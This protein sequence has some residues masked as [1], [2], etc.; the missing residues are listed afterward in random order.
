[1]IRQLGEITMRYRTLLLV[2]GFL[3]TFL[4]AACSKATSRGDSAQAQILFVCEHGNVKSLMAA[5]YFNE[6]AQSRQLSFRAISRGT[7]PDSNTVPPAIV[8][9]LRA[10]GFDVSSFHPTALISADL[11]SST[12]VILIGVALPATLSG[13]AVEPETWSD[14]PPASINY[15]AARDAIKAHIAE[16]IDQLERGKS[17]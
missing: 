4:L 5:T 10:D 17:H 2:L 14:V 13:A 15:A 8:A 12:H 7:A 3:M 1:V 16:L 9:G 6:M 11:I